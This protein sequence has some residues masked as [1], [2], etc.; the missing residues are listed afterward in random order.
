MEKQDSLLPLV[1][2]R[3]WIGLPD[4]GIASIKVKVDTGARSSAIHAINIEQFEQD[5]R[6]RVRFQVAPIQNDGDR[7]VTVETNLCE[8]RTVTDSGGHQQLRPVVITS[9]CLGTAQWPVELTL[10]NRDVMGFRM[11]LGR[12]AV[13]DRFWVDP[14]RS[15]L[16]SQRLAKDK[17][18]DVSE[19]EASEEQG[20]G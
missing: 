12:Q 14:S 19:G 4:F 3:E 16:Q 11:L 20:P 1:G 7:L 6:R 8:E 9:I 17:G 2:W 10:T 18:L 5:G 15:Y 13:R